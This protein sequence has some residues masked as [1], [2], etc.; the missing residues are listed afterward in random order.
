ME[1]AMFTTTAVTDDLTRPSPEDPV[2]IVMVDDDPSEHVLMLAAAREANISSDFTFFEDGADALLHLIGAPVEDLPD[3]IVLDLRM[4]GLDGHST[5]D[6]LQ[7]DPILWQV[8][9]VVFTSSPRLSDLETSIDRGAVSYVVKPSDF[10]TMVNNVSDL[11]DLARRGVA[12]RQINELSSA[13]ADRRETIQHV[14]VLV[15]DYLLQLQLES[16]ARIV[17]DKV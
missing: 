9:V 14:G 15:E 10:D 6:E 7:A 13:R 2:R 5:L 8:P 16:A 11:C 17:Q 12:P 1:P 3:V 4:P